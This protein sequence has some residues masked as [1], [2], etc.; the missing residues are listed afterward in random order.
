MTAPA[1]MIR[2]NAAVSEALDARFASEKGL[3]GKI[4]D[5]PL[6]AQKGHYRRA[7]LLAALDIGDVGEKVC[8]DFGMGSWGFAGIYPKLQGC[9]FAYGLDISKR[10]IEISRELS[11]NGKYRYKQNFEYLQSDGLDLPLPDGSVDIVFGGESIEHVRFPKRFLAE[12]Y[13]V[14]KPGGEVVLTTPNRDAFLYKLQNDAY[15]VGPEHFWLFNAEELSA[16]VSEFFEIQEFL[17]FNGSIYRDLDK[18]VCDGGAAEEW[19]RMFLTRPQ[20]ATGM[21]LRAVRRTA[22]RRERYQ[23]RTLDAKDVLVQGPSQLLDLEFGLRGQ[24]IDSREARIQFTCP[25]ASGL[26]IYFWTHAWSGRTRVRCGDQ[27][28]E[29]SLY[30]KDPGWKPV[31]FIFDSKEQHH[32]EIRATGER[33]E[34]ALAAQVIF[35]EALAYTR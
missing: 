24:M 10:A 25:A 32:V 22:E 17:G 4:E 16:A 31:H 11:R 13:R 1:S 33:D 14:L 15:C 6:I 28:V 5:I 2:S 7:E 8:V 34:R 26:V 19:A 35:F 9:K 30:S 27:T 18:T 29:H 23:V 12:C 3:Y 20:D 21:V